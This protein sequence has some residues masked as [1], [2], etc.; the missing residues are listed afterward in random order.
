MARPGE[1]LR[2]LQVL[3][4]LDYGEV[5]RYVCDVTNALDR[6]R[7]RVGVADV[8]RTPAPP[9]LALDIARHTINLRADQT[10]GMRRTL[11][12]WRNL[13]RFYRIL[14]SGPYDLVATYEP[15]SGMWAWLAARLAG[16]PIV[17]TPT[18]GGYIPTLN[19][20]RLFERPGLRRL[21][22]ATAIRR[23]IGLS[24][25]VLAWLRETIHAPADKIAKSW[26]GLDL[27]AL[28]SGLPDRRLAARLGLEGGPVIAL[29]GPPVDARR[30]TLALEMVVQLRRSVPGVALL[31]TGIVPE[32][33]EELEQ[34]AALAGPAV[35]VAFFDLAAPLGPPLDLA[36]LALVVAPGP[37]FSPPALRAMAFA[38][39]LLVV[40]EQPG[41]MAMAKGM[42]QQ[43]LNGWVLPPQ[44]GVI[45]ATLSGVLPLTDLLR[46]MGTGS[47]QIAERDF[48]LHR[49]I[50]QIEAVY[51]ALTKPAK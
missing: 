42:I 20:R 7:F 24:D 3:N 17:H 14:R 38:K 51:Q 45:A 5:A 22:G 40:A 28:R 11:A 6:R 43:G 37:N 48:D 9:S 13:W 26:P 30:L 29:V 33:R 19:E 46:S 35:P 25:Y 2:V 31:V 41:E 4:S 10:L 18:P 16:V 12:D 32:E 1:R 49:H 8:A 34:A 21:T 47:R 36:L 44:P 50:L 39:P 23:Y 27:H 15:A